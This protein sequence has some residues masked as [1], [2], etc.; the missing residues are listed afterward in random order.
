MAAFK[1]AGADLVKKDCPPLLTQ[2][3]LMD[4]QSPAVAFR[5]GLVPIHEFAEGTVL[6]KYAKGP[7]CRHAG[8]QHCK[9]KFPA[10]FYRLVQCRVNVPQE[11]S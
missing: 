2:E 10:R 1:V 7:A 9:P 11:Q 8:R 4:E 3:D 6:P 5:F